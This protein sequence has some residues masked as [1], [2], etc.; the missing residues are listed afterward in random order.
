MAGGGFYD[1]KKEISR[2]GGLSGV[3]DQVTSKRNR[4][5]LLAVAGV[6]AVILLWHSFPSVGAPR[7]SRDRIPSSDRKADQPPMHISPFTLADY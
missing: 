7:V 1:E 6:I 4:R 5:P 2:S 3:Y